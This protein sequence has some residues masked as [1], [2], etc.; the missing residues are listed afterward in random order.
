MEAVT[1]HG[2]TTH[3]TGPPSRRQRMLPPLAIITGLSLATV[4]LHLR[5]PHVEGSWGF[6]PSN[7]LFGIYCPGCG[8]LRAVHDLT[9]LDLGAAASSNL[10]LVLSLPVIGWVLG[11]SLVEAWRGERHAPR[12]LGTKAFYLGFVGLLLV[13]TVV[14][15]LPQG[16]WLAP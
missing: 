5:D 13:F 9:N 12:V 14:R 15:N 3:R 11:R 8:G 16:A 1:Q 2:P 10:L 6:C 7:L 4:A